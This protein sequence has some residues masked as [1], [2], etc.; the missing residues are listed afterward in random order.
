MLKGNLDFGVFISKFFQIFEKEAKFYTDIYEIL[1]S[2]IKEEINK[3]KANWDKKKYGFF[4]TEEMINYVGN[5][6]ETV[7]SYCN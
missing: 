1:T 2:E 7:K 4:F 6:T 3:R 5:L